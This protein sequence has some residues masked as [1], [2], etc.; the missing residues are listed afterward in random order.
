VRTDQRGIGGMI[1]EVTVAGT[2]GAF[3]WNDKIYDGTVYY[4]AN[5]SAEEMKVVADGPLRAVVET[6]G[7]YLD[8][9]KPAAS[10]PCATYRDTFTEVVMLPVLR[11]QLKVINDWLEDDQVEDVVKQ[12]T[13]AFPA[14][15]LSRITAMS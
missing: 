7:E 6:Q 10:H 9:S 14:P 1:R 3:T 12:L 2:T 13:A 4:L 11:E 8:G 5:H 15:D